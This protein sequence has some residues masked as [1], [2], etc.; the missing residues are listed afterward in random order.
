M[1]RYRRI[2]FGADKHL[3]CSARLP[4]CCWCPLPA[5][6]RSAR[7]LQRVWRQRMP[8]MRAPDHRSAGLNIQ[9]E[10]EVDGA[11]TGGTV[12]QG[13]G[14]Y[15]DHG[16]H[17]AR[18]MG[19]HGR[20]GAH[21]KIVTGTDRAYNSL[22]TAMSCSDSPFSLSFTR[23][24]ASLLAWRQSEASL[25]NVVIKALGLRGIGARATSLG[26]RAR[27]NIQV[28]IFQQRYEKHTMEVCRD[29]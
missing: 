1:H 23:C 10:R 18:G 2:I 9:N 26:I 24:L 5:A 6:L 20:M 29:P 19:G 25:L 4:R 21:M 12:Q 27:V 17:E 3:S 13:T 7:T 22:S 14:S 11:G 16:L 28:F 15:Q 8:A